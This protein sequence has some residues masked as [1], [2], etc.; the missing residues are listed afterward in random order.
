MFESVLRC[1]GTLLVYSLGLKF[2]WW[3]DRKK[4]FGVRYHDSKV[5]I[6]IKMMMPECIPPTLCINFLP[7]EGFSAKFASRAGSGPSFCIC[8]QGFARGLWW[9]DLFACLKM[10]RMMTNHHW[11]GRWRRLGKVLSFRTAFW[12]RW[13]M[14]LSGWWAWLGIRPEL[15]CLQ[16][17][18]CLRMTMA[19]VN[20]NLQVG[21]REY[22]AARSPP[23]LHHRPLCAWE[24]CLLGR[25]VILFNFH[26]FRHHCRHHHYQHLD[27]NKP[28]H[29][30]VPGTTITWFVCLMTSSTMLTSCR[31]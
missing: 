18:P 7:T 2:R 11:W 26:P 6:M 12:W 19:T 28:S 3:V 20:R 8:K 16:V 15:L 25:A 30:S 27:K 13:C 10:G 29:Q 22:R 24:P 23:R 1:T 31:S 5:V 4:Y 9:C 17:L 14:C 21:D